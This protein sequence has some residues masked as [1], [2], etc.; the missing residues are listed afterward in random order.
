MLAASPQT[1]VVILTTFGEEARRRGM[2]PGTDASSQALM[3]ELQK[4]FQRQQ[5]LLKSID[6]QAQ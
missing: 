5:A 2:E 6:Y 4:A 1:K 3:D